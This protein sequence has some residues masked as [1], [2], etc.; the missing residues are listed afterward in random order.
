MQKCQRPSDDALQIDVI[1]DQESD[2]DILDLKSR[3]KNAKAP[4]QEQKNT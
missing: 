3:I 2:Q 1:R 4:K